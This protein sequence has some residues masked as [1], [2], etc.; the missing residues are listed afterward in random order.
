MLPRYDVTGALEVAGCYTSR[1]IPPGNRDPSCLIQKLSCLKL[2]RFFLRLS[3]WLHMASITKML[4][5]PRKWPVLLKW[6][7]TGFSMHHRVVV[8][9]VVW[10][11]CL[12]VCLCVCLSVRLC[13]TANLGIYADRHQMMGTNGISGVW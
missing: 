2:S 1:F 12:S 6:A 10:S 4:R 5:S 13:V 7:A 8:H 9:V 11:V 3:S